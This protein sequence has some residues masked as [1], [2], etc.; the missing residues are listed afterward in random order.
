[1]RLTLPA[2]PGGNKVI[3]LAALCTALCAGLVSACGSTHA[4]GAGS[5]GGSTPSVPAAPS[6]TQTVTHGPVPAPSATPAAVSLVIQVVTSP[7]AVP[8]RW[9]L[10]CDPTGGNHPDAQAAC[11]ALA[12]V[13]DPFAPVPRGIMCPMI[14]GGPQ[15]A[16]IEGSWHGTPIQATFSK[17]NGCETSR[18]NKIAPVFGTTT[19]LVH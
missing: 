14:V 16:T 19:G 11:R 2:T 5:A 8:Q 17:V 15:T 13:K 7:G 9:T 4:A 1:M 6:A 3:A 12:S 10:Q 18:W